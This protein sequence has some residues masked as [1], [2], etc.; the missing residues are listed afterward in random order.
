MT[1]SGPAKSISTVTRGL[2]AR[3]SHG[4]PITASA[5]RVLGTA[6]RAVVGIR[7]GIVV[8]AAAAV[9]TNCGATAP[10]GAV[11]VTPGTRPASGTQKA[12]NT[13][14]PA[15]TPGPSSSPKPAS[16]SVRATAAQPA[17]ASAV[18]A[19]Q[20]P[21]PTVTQ[22]PVPAATAQ[23]PASSAD[24]HTWYTSSAGNAR[25][26]YC[27]GDDGWKG[28]S[29]N[30]LRSYPSEAELLAAWSGRRTKHPDS[31]C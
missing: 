16:T 20:T 23:A 1:E 25:Y 22:A 3:L 14:R 29:Q 27:D 15:N 8:L 11:T 7:L 5:S 6:W 24:G 4:A 9:I 12:T 21:T 13:P 26:Y 10:E 2:V 18:A 28:L 19:A 17:Q 30:N 31:K